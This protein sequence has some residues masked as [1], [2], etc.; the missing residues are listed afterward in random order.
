MQINEQP[1]H[2][3]SDRPAPRFAHQVAYN[4]NTKS[5]FLHGGSTG[6]KEGD[7]PSTGEAAAADIESTSTEKKM[8]D[9]WRMELKRSVF[10]LLPESLTYAH[11]FILMVRPGPEEIIRQAKFHIRRQQ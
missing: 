6:K 8:D 3:P 10:F 11:S 5:V 7:Q 1:D 9:F 2:P 4:P